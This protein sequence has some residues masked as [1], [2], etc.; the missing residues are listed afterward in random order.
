MTICGTCQKPIENPH[1]NQKFHH[2]FCMEEGRRKRCRE[3]N[4]KHLP[5]KTPVEMI[6]LYC[7]KPYMTSRDDSVSCR[8]DKCKNAYRRALAKKKYDAMS[9]EE[10]KVF[11]ASKKKYISSP[12]SLEQYKQSAAVDLLCKCPGCGCWHIKRMEYGYERKSGTTPLFN[13]ENWP[14]C[15]NN[16]MPVYDN[17]GYFGY[18]S[19]H[20]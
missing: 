7:K 1:G 9:I 5:R 10:R 4:Q 20:V 13:C 2:G 17:A 16:N 14:G 15:I 19:A 18:N 8:E 12:L 11:K 6:C 3:H